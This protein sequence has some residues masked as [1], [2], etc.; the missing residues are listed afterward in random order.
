ML[1]SV[2]VSVITG[3]SDSALEIY[4]SLSLSRWYDSDRL[5]HVFCH[6]LGR[7]VLSR[8]FDAEISG[9]KGLLIAAAG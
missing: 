9:E 6:S 2:T 3:R 1:R 7:L 4:L 5:C 8:D